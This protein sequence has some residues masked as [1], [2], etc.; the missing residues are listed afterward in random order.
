M[1]SRAEEVHMRSFVVLAGLLVAGCVEVGQMTPLDDTAKAIGTPKIEIVLKHSAHGAV[2]VTMPDGEV[3]QGA[4]QVL[5]SS[6]VAMAASGQYVATGLPI[7]SRHVSLT[8]T[9]VRTIMKCEGMTN[10]EGH[11]SGLCETNTGAH[12]RVQF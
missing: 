12:F 2:A 8:A 4:Y 9:G 6:A 3:L 1:V 10:A 11:G 5:A 7:G